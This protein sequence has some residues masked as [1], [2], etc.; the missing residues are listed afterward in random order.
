[1][2]RITARLVG[3]GLLTAG[4]LLATVAL[5]SAD[6]ETSDVEIKVQ[7]PVDAV[8]CGTPST[9]T[10]LGLSID[11]TNAAIDAE[12]QTPGAQGNSDGQNSTDGQNATGQGSG[13]TQGG[14][15]GQSGDP[16]ENSGGCAALMVAR[17]ANVT[18]SSDTPPLTATSVEPSGSDA[19][20]V[21]LQA[22]LQA[23]DTTAKT[24]TLL[25]LLIDVSNATVD[26]ASDTSG[27]GNTQPVDLSQLMLGQSI[28]AKLDASQLPALVATSL[29]VKNF[30]NQVQVEVDDTNG[31]P[32]D[33]VNETGAPM[34]DVNVNVTETVNVQNPAA[35]AGGAARTK[36]LVRLQTASN[37]AFVLSGLPT[38]RATIVVARASTGVTKTAR[39]QVTVVPN[40]ARRVRLR[41]RSR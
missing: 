28:E 27:D 11:I 13:D 33:D 41:L 10:I 1:M 3:A 14:A 35:T 16:G 18:L 15:D 24:I 6:D 12:S 9:V 26:G 32:I 39:K 2:R 4:L 25:G 30:A 34:N 38:G 5:V 37:G 7:G 21:D 23:V 36:K 19:A 17:A 40:T 20:Q 31:S 8:S 29:E 22:P